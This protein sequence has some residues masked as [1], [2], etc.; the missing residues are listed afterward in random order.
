[1]KRLAFARERGGLGENPPGERVARNEVRAQGE[2]SPF[3][4]HFKMTDDK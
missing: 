4:M 2:A 3:K 1:M